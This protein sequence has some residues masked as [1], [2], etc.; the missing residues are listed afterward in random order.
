MQAAHLGLI[1]LDEMSVEPFDEFSKAVK[2]PALELKQ[3]ARPNPGPYAALEWLIP[4][5]VF[6]YIGKSYFDGF[7]KEAG[8]DHYLLLKKG[9]HSL[10]S[11]FIGPSAAR[12]KLIFLKGKTASQIPKYSMLF[13]VVAE[14]RPGLSLKLLL[15]PTFTPE[16][17]NKAVELFMELLTSIHDS[18]LEAI[19]GGGPD[20][21]KPVGG[22]LLV[23][24]NPLSDDLEVVD[25]LPKHVRDAQ[26]IRKGGSD[27]P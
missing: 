25:P 18:N 12:V 16:Q 19:S 22:F 17:C 20:E 5:A 27:E 9:I 1:Y 7:L 8:K 21:A 11:N 15:E 3:I 23:A 26:A 4:T 6:I 10:T 13:S 24:F 14:L 2:H